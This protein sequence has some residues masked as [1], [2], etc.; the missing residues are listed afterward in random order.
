MPTK[1]CSTCKNMKDLDK[2]EVDLRY[3]SGHR[4]QCAECRYTTKSAKDAK[5]AG[6]LKRKY[7]VTLEEYEAKL[8][9]QNGLCAICNREETRITRPNAKKYFNGEAPRLS[10]DHDHATGK[11]RGLLCYKCNIGIGQLQDSVENLES[12]IAYLKKWSSS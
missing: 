4:S 10:L 1:S 6:H 7:G 8:A 3:K 11:V 2:F 9:E 12:A 5:L